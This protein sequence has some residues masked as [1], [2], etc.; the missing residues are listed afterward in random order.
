MCPGATVNVERKESSMD[1]LILVFVL[2]VIVAL[3]ALSA[4]TSVSIPAP[5]TITTSKARKLAF[6]DTETGGL[7]VQANPLL[8]V[9]LAIV[10]PVTMAV[11]VR[12]SAKVLPAWGTVHPRAA[13]VN[14]YTPEGWVDARPLGGA[15]AELATL[16]TGCTPV[17]HNIQ[18]DLGFLRAAYEHAGMPFPRVD[19]HSL[20]TMS[21]AW[22]LL[23]S[24]RIASLSLNAVCTALGVSNEGAHDAAADVERTLAVARK[25]LGK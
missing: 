1:I 8:A 10:D 7:D 13:E 18:F 11:L 14:G 5:T 19:Y 20:D 2:V 15:L 3:G 17:G 21:L 12:W 25:L 4:R 22:P 6:L 16:L 23:A 9:G 24:G